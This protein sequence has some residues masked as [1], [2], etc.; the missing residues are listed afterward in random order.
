M[1]DLRGH[2][3]SELGEADGSLRQLSQ[4]LLAFMNAITLDAAVLAGFSL[5][6]TIAMRTAID[7]PNRVLGLALIATSSRVN[8]A[9]ADWYRQRADAVANGDP[10]LRQILDRD[11]EDV[12]RNRVEEIEDGLTI[13]RQATADPKGY[14]NACRAM[15]SLHEV[16]LDLE[17]GK[18]NA[19]TVAVAGEVDQHCPPR[20]S[21]I[22]AARIPNCSLQI[23][24]A[25]GH[26]I[27]IERP[28]EVADA[29][30]MVERK[31]NGKGYIKR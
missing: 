3:Q 31:V 9:A 23:L 20:A 6:G 14:A 21:E 28:K 17:L 22:I 1:Y 16:P 4:D 2:G 26:P 15:F 12:Y 29:I 18:L 11:T 27:P 13:R 5:G 10:Q 7:D 8:A 24:P 30:R 19:P 25:T